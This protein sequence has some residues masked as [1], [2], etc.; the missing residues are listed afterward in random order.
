MSIKAKQ[1]INKCLEKIKDRSFDEDTVRL[2]LITAREHIKG[3]GLFK[4]FAHFI[5]HSSRN[6]GQFHRK[7]NSRYMKFKLAQDQ[8]QS[9]ELKK[10]QDSIKTEAGLSD[11]MLGGVSVEKVQKNLFTIL[12]H[13]GLDDLPEEHL[14]KYTGFSKAQVKE[15][16]KEFYIKKGDFYYLRTNTTERLIELIKQ[17]PVSDSLQEQE[18]LAH[19][20]ENAQKTAAT[21]KSTMDRVVKVV[22]GAIHFH[23]VFEQPAFREDIIGAISQLIDKFKLDKSYL[24]NVEQESDDILFCLMTILHDST[25]VFFDRSEAHIFLC[26]YLG[27]NG[28]RLSQQGYDVATDLYENGVYALYLESTNVLTFPLFVSDLPIKRYLSFDKFKSA[29]FSSNVS[30]SIWTTAVRLGTEIE[31]GD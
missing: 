19:K 30:H 16:L 5:A 10:L 21:I 11:F 31:L 28:T 9:V 4:E 18:W 14:I 8:V 27:D 26:L 22:R 7:V 2:L 24:K 20:L 3:E 12:Y 23:S 13:D 15:M 25:F 29:D 17:L 6:Q 1:T